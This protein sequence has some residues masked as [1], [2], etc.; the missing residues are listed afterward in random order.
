LQFADFN[1]DGLLDIMASGFSSYQLRWYKN[2]GNNEFNSAV[3]LGPGTVHPAIADLN[4]D[5]IPEVISTTNSNKLTLYRYL[6]EL[7]AISPQEFIFT[8]YQGPSGIVT[9]DLD[10]DGLLDIV[11]TTRGTLQGAEQ[12]ITLLNRGNLRFDNPV[13]FV[14]DA[15]WSH[16]SYGFMLAEDI[17]GDRRPE[18][19]M[20]SSRYGRIGWQAYDP[21]TNNFSNAK[22][23]PVDMEQY[24]TVSNIAFGDIDMDG[25][26]DIV[27]GA[28]AS[29]AIGNQLT[30]MRQTEDG[31]FDDKIVLE[32]D[33]SPYYDIQVEDI[34]QDGNLD[35]FYRSGSD[36]FW[37]R[38]IDGLGDFGEPT[39]IFAPNIFGTALLSDFDLDGDLDALIL[40]TWEDQINWFSNENGIFS[41]AQTVIALDAISDFRY[42][43]IDN[44]GRKDL[45]YYSNNSALSWRK[46]EQ[47]VGVFGPEQ[48]IHLSLP[49]GS[50]TNIIIEDLDQD[51]D[52]DILYRSQAAYIFFL[53]L[54]GLGY[55]SEPTPIPVGDDIPRSLCIGDFDGDADIDVVTYIWE[56]QAAYL[57]ENQLDFA[58]LAG[59][60]FLDDNENGIQDPDEN[61]LSY[62]YVEILPTST[63]AL[64]SNSNGIFGFVVDDG[65]YNISCFP[66]N[67]F[68]L[69]TPATVNRNVPAEIDTPVTFGLRAEAEVAEV[70][71]NITSA[72]TRCGFTVPFLIDVRNVGTLP[73]DIQIAVPLDPLVSYVSASPEPDSIVNHTAFWYIPELPVYESVSIELLLEMPGVEFLGEYISIVGT[74]QIDANNAPLT[75]ND[76][77]DYKSEI[78]CSFDPNDKLVEPNIIGYDNYTLFGDTLEYTVRFQNTGTDTAFTVRIEDYLDPHLDWTSL[79]ILSASHD[80]QVSIDQRS[81][82]AAFLFNNILLPD[83]TTNEIG[84]HG[85]IK[86]QIEQQPDLPEFTYVENQAAIYFDFNPPIYTNTTENILV[87]QYPLLLDIVPPLCA[88]SNDGHILVTDDLPVFESYSWSTG[89]DGSGIDSISAGSYQLCV[90]LSNGLTLDT[91]IELSA[92][93]PLITTISQQD[94][95]CFGGTDGLLQTSVDGGSLPYLFNWNTG[96]TS[97]LIDNLSAEEYTFIVTDRNSC[98]DTLTTTVLSPDELLFNSMITPETNNNGD[99]AISILMTGG[100]SPYLFSW[101]HD[102]EQTNSSIYDLVSGTYHLMVIDA[103]N[104]QADTSF[105]VDMVTSVGSLAAENEF[106]VSPN[107][108]DGAIVIALSPTLTNTDWKLVI[109]NSLGQIIQLIQDKDSPLVHNR[110]TT[111]LPKGIYTISFFQN[112]QLI[113]STKIVVN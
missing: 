28:E 99:G 68:S 8:M 57:Q 39:L 6:A 88:N 2:T 51:G 48:V 37:R 104:C 103:K 7:D 40:D 30:W 96:A 112:N 31:N 23:L 9:P 72:P 47:E 3:N 4:N 90:Q 60:V 93:P 111:S 49:G 42:A 53:N 100:T 21:S 16:Y 13:E 61:N 59:N 29:L 97:T 69:S 81:G 20:G 105:T 107:P 45:I 71:L 18:L 77:V 41:E 32:S 5:G 109:Y 38:N 89:A 19:I 98:T 14:A 33:Q 110:M 76:A 73:G 52:L 108:S 83:S 43:D 62:Q 84:S 11:A 10:N 82:K 24:S 50:G 101:D 63:S 70:D 94:V 26:K 1:G 17:T 27:Y 22:L 46:S 64:S 95:S 79:R 35:L 85:F 15:D 86:Y 67:Y 80:Y 55:F 102:P 34:D 58:T 113:E 56:E 36:V 25:D 78:N 74:A 65:D 92:P 44:D 75:I 66:T 91:L 106:I 12:G 87:S 54:D